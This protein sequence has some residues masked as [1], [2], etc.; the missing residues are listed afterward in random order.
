MG[1]FIRLCSCE[2]TKIFKKKSTKIMIII[3][4][5][6]LFLSAGMA[7]L[8][9]KLTDVAED[10]ANIDYKEHMR[11]TIEMNK[12]EIDNDAVDELSKTYMKA[13]NDVYQ[14]AIDNDVNIYTSYWKSD[15]LNK[16]MI[17]LKSEQY[18][19]EA[20]GETSIAEAL[21]LDYDK[22]AEMIKNDDFSGFMKTKRDNLKRDFDAKKISEEEYNDSLH[23]VEL[24]EKYEIG[25]TY[26]K[27]D[28]WKS[29]IIND[30]EMCQYN[31]RYGV[32]QMTMEALTEKSYE[33]TKNNI[34]IYEYRLEHNLAP[35]VS[36]RDGT[37]LGSARKV[38]DN[39]ASSFGMLVL[40]VMMIIIAGG[41][42][43]TEVSKGTI[44]FWSFTPN[45]R[46]KILLSKLLVATG[47]LFVITIVMSVLSTLIGNIFFGASNAQGYLY[48]SNGVVHE[49]NYVIYSIL[50]NLVAA[51]E[52]F[53]F[54]VLAM[55]LSTVVRN[56]AASVGISIAAYLGGSII[57]T[58][59]NTFIKA[60]WTKFI[61]FNNLSLVDR[62]F[63]N[64]YTEV[65]SM[66]VSSVTGNISIKFSL[67]YLAICTIIMII[68]MFDSFRKRDIV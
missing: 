11:V 48:V 55:M 44:K 20:T 10:Y 5:V 50:Y 8:S 39:M 63:T 24:T 62:I 59:I 18:L 57:C 17:N 29:Q 30:I 45:R 51:I 60:D 38:Y 7:S 32:N 25:K 34:L 14:L 42:I 27:E 40:S 56:T 3:L 37:S 21:K 35:S 65:A 22:Y 1:N 4:I 6:A 43:S 58:I 53:V 28:I 12:N 66:M 67:I 9:K 16:D 52:V 26:N 13:T 31:L 54:L 19:S 41:S 15:V 36:G 47:I 33:K 49:I 61:P 46:W 2:F 64:D 23:I 68:T